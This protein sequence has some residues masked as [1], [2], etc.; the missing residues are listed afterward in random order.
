MKI[1]QIVGLVNT[2]LA[3]ETLTYNQMLSFLDDTINDIN[4]NLNACFPT[5]SEVTTVAQA[6]SVYD[7]IPDQ[8]ITSV[9]VIGA[10]YKFYTT[11]EEGLNVATGYQQE[12]ERGLFYMVRDYSASVPEKYQAQNRGYV[13]G[14]APSLNLADP[15][16]CPSTMLNPDLRLIE[17]PR[18]LPGPKGDK[19]DPGYTPRKG[20]D[21]FDGLPGPQGPQ[22]PQ[23]PRGTT[24]A[25]GPKGATG[26]QGL[27]GPKGAKGE[28]GPQ[29]AKGDPGYTPQKG[30][31]YLTPEDIESLGL[32]GNLRVWQPNIEYKTG[33]IVFAETPI[34][35]A[36]HKGFMLF[37]CIANHISTN[38]GTPVNEKD[39]HL[40]WN[41]HDICVDKAFADG[42]GNNIHETYATREELITAE[43][44]AKG[45]ATGYV[46]DTVSDLDLWLQDE[47]NVSKLVLGDNFYIREVDVPDYWWDGT[48]KQQL[49]TQKVDLSEYYTKKET[50]GA[51]VNKIGVWKPDT[52]Y[53]KGDIVYA[54]MRNGMMG[55]DETVWCMFECLADHTSQYGKD[56]WDAD[57]NE[58]WY[59]HYYHVF[60]AYCDGNGKFI[61][62]T[63]ATKE[64][65]ACKKDKMAIVDFVNGD[66]VLLSDNTEYI[67][68][69]PISVLN[70]V[71]P[72]G[73]FI[74]SLYFTL[75]SEGDITIT[76]PESK[77]IGEVPE[78][79]NGETWELSI[80]NGVAVGGK[81]V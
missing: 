8:Y 15:L 24:G 37:E 56:P 65:V 61:H 13:E 33:D 49:E 78:F 52:N 25:T 50:D 1:T 51:L 7:A 54:L 14:P 4:T 22:G 11:D 19:G 72:E 59:L 63:Y 66:E 17:G 46:F 27:P 81:V 18:G 32:S 53:K 16:T 28:R 60:G 42:L 5:F 58:T 62:E 44:I 80:K 6:D 9:V 67:A 38:V 68:S 35:S 77:Y 23:G 70:L 75:A 31:D 2:K 41:L 43:A 30:I 45:R 20:I 79:K 36:T 55:K 3:G 69:E 29:G 76:L 21:Y 48:E 64:E 40:F 73:D 57:G 12:Y 39:F 34:Y 47:S 71:Y 10:A 26:T 74:C